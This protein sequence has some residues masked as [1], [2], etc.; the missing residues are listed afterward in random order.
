MFY[1]LC[2]H[3]HRHTPA[4]T[5]ALYHSHIHIQHIEIHTSTQAWTKIKALFLTQ[6]LTVIAGKRPLFFQA[7]LKTHIKY[8]VDISTKG[9]CMY[10]V[11]LLRN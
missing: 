6:I 2:A 10:W 8:P 5:C 3:M 7:I 4:Y 11:D 9:Q 1:G